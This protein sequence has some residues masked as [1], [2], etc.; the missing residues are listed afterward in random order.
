MIFLSFR[1][2]HEPLSKYSSAVLREENGTQFVGQTLNRGQI[3]LHQW[4]RRSSG[5][6]LDLCNDV[7]TIF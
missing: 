4:R 6:K 5:S 1:I 3:R 7:Q 2:S